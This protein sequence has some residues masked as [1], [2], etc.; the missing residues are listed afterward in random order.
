MSVVTGNDR[1]SI[2]YP[3]YVTNITNAI[4]YNIPAYVYNYIVAQILNA[5]IVNLPPIS[6]VPHGWTLT[7]V[8]NAGELFTVN[9]NGSDLLIYSPMFGT[10]NSSFSQNASFRYVAFHSSSGNFWTIF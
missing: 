8:N 7:I 1:F 9:A 2:N 3:V 6:S 5:S 10:S 4:T